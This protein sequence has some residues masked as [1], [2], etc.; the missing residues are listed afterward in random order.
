MITSTSTVTVAPTSAAVAPVNLVVPVCVPCTS[1]VT[2]T[3][4]PSLVCTTM[5]FCDAADQSENC[6]LQNEAKI[7]EIASLALRDGGQVFVNGHLVVFEKR[8]NNGKQAAKK[9]AKKA[10]GQN[11][12][13]A[14]S[15]S[16]G[17][18]GL[19]AVAAGAFLFAA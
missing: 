2:E 4:R 5:I 10:S 18:F 7:E 3:V 1:V 12:N 17:V 15:V 8:E 16:G 14:S 11:A 19:V 9:A 13:D 6:R